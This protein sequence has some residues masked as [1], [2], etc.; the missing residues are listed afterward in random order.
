M[1]R[2][3][4]CAETSLLT[5]FQET[6]RYILFEATAKYLYFCYEFRS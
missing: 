3:G 5:L 6:P 1:R 2:G 4:K